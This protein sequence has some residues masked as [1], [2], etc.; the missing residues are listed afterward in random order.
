MKRWILPAV[1]VGVGVFLMTDKGR[2]TQEHL[3]ESF[4]GWCD[5]LVH[6][7]ETLQQRLGQAHST[8]EQFN[9]ALQGLSS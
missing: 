1:A 3:A 9:R 6:F 7:N 2:R 8:L 5:S 4:H